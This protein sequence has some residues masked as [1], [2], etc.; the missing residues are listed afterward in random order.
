MAQARHREASSQ[1]IN[2]QLPNVEGLWTGMK[3]Y[4]LRFQDLIMQYQANRTLPPLL[5][6]SS[7]TS[8][9]GSDSTHKFKIPSLTHRRAACTH[10]TMERIHGGYKCHNCR[11]ISH[12]DWVYSCTQDEKVP[13]SGALPVGP[14]VSDPFEPRS[15]E[16][17]D[18]VL[19]FGEDQADL[20]LA[21]PQLSSWV[22]NAIRDGHYTP[23]QVKTL[24]A[25]R[26]NVIQRTLISIRM[27]EQSQDSDVN[28]P[29]ESRLSQHLYTEPP[30]PLPATPDAI[31]ESAVSKAGFRAPLCVEPKLKLYPHCKYRACHHCRPTYRDRTWQCFEEIFSDRSPIDLDLLKA[32]ERPMASVSLLRNIG[33][34]SQPRGRPRLRS[35][36]SRS[37]YTLNDT[38]QIVH[39]N[40]AYHKE[41]TLP[42]SYDITDIRDDPE[43][44]GFRESMKRAF[45]GLLASRRSKNYSV[46]DKTKSDAAA[47]STEPDA[48]EFDVGLYRELS[49]EL[50]SEAAS[51]PLP[52]DD[53]L[54][55]ITASTEEIVAVTEEAAETGAADLIL[56]V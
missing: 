53:S 28:S 51:I 14:T 11:Q 45:K 49:D 18:E 34:R 42:T 2:A 56:A 37:L 13:A 39:K 20:E 5:T 33:L 38:G 48:V 27:F 15:I 30:S 41:S 9:Q 40:N 32:N 35:F 1:D 6:P 55:A 8:I 4:A 36:D 31:R 46:S 29:I 43:S 52:L 10:L 23:E 44:K 12:F 24:R 3:P 54:G 26:E 25:Q 47:L 7:L 17:N 22:E 19:P 16:T 21:R 50:L